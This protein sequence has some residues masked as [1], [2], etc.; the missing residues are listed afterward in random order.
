MAL[1]FSDKNIVY[2]ALSGVYGFVTDIR[3]WLFDIGWIKTTSFDIPIISVGNL[4][5]GGTGKT[6]HTEYLISLLQ[7]EYKIAV[8][9]RGYKRK[10]KGFVL[11]DKNANATTIGD[12]SFQIRQKY[13][14]ITVAVCEKRVI[15][16]SK[17]LELQPDLQVIILD[18]AFQH[19]YIKPGLSLLLTDYSN[20]YTEDRM[21]PAGSLREKA[22]GSRR[23][24][25][26]VVTKCPG[27]DLT[28]FTLICDKIDAAKI[29]D[30]YFSMYIYEELNPLFPKVNTEKWTY[31]RLKKTGATVFLMT[32]IASPEKLRQYLKSFTEDVR[33]LQFPDHHNFGKKDFELL[34]EHFDTKGIENKMI[35]VTEKDAVRIMDNPDFPDELQPF[36]YTIPINVKLLKDQERFT[37]KIRN[38]VRTNLRNG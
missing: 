27:K 9:S 16:V 2:L 37:K 25:I 36:V 15:G 6:P 19:R 4:A 34:Q 33:L 10:T 23:A 30:I 17:L 13:P 29:Q 12:E 7:D 14:D 32:G 18:D 1:K 8:L 24:D 28:P 38:Y 22:K 35:V 11:A 20:L 5:V 3:N 26:V 31:N 21:M